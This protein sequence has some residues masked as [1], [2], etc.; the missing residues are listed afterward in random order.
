MKWDTFKDV[1]VLRTE[2]RVAEILSRGGK[3]EFLIKSLIRWT[4]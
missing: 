4:K 1:E 3:E 2:N